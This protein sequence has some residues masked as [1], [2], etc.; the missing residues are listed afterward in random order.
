MSAS[1]YLIRRYIQPN[2]P[3]LRPVAGNGRLIEI[4]G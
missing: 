4:E 2:L 3:G 1:D